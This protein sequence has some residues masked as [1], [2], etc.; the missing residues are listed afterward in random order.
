[1]Q[2]SYVDINGDGSAEPLIGTPDSVHALII[3]I[4]MISPVFAKSVG[5]FAKGGYL[6][7]HEIL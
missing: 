6:E 1:M 7:H 5:T 2:Y 3:L 4:M